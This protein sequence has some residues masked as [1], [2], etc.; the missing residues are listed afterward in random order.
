MKFG[1]ASEVAARVPH[2]LNSLPSPNCLIMAVLQNG[3]HTAQRVLPDPLTDLFLNPYF[4]D[5]LQLC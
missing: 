2:S 5:L 1:R 3:E 4:S